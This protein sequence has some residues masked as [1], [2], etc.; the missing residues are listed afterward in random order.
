MTRPP[1]LVQSQLVQ[2]AG[3]DDYLFFVLGLVA[4][5]T[6]FLDA[7]G[8]ERA[9][10]RD[11]S[12]TDRIIRRRSGLTYSSNQPMS[13]GA[14]EQVID[15]VD[16]VRSSPVPVGPGASW[17]KEW[18]HFGPARAARGH[19]PESELRRRRSPG[20]RA[21]RKGREDDPAGARA[22]VGGRDRI[23]A[24]ARHRDR[25]GPAGSARQQRGAVR[26]RSVRSCPRP[27]KV[28]P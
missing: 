3:D 2:A 26:G 15:R 27:W 6:A 25:P 21:G 4:F 22:R 1:I 17:E 5:A 9:T 14:L 19:H 16:G 23:H 24:R 20:R 13:D 8:E 11:R 18:F 10:V 12:D 28:D 7:L